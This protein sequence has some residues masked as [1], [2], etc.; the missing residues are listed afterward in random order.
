[1]CFKT[2]VTL[3]LFGRWL[4]VGD[5]RRNFLGL[6]I[7]WACLKREGVNHITRAA[8]EQRA[9]MLEFA[10]GM[11]GVPWPLPAV[12]RWEDVRDVSSAS[13]V[14]M[15]GSGGSKAVA[16]LV[17]RPMPAGPVLVPGVPTRFV[18]RTKAA[19]GWPLLPLWTA[20]VPFVGWWNGLGNDLA[21]EVPA[22]ADEDGAIIEATSS[23]LA[24]GEGS[25]PPAS[26]AERSLVSNFEGLRTIVRILLRELIG[27][28]NAQTKERDFTPVLA[29]TL[30]L[31]QD[32]VECSSGST[33]R[34]IKSL[35]SF[36][37]VV[38]A[39]KRLMRPYREFLRTRKPGFLQ[40]LGPILPPIL[41]FMRE[42]DDLHPGLVFGA[43]CIKAEFLNTTPQGVVAVLEVLRRLGAFDFRTV[44]GQP[45]ANEWTKSQIVAACL[46]GYIYAEL[47]APARSASSAEA[48]SATKATFGEAINLFISFSADALGGGDSS[49]AGL[50]ELLSHVKTIVG[51][52]QQEPHISPKSLE[53]ALGFINSAAEGARLAEGFKHGMGAALMADAKLLLVSGELDAQCEEQFLQGAQNIL[54][55]G[56]ETTDDG[57]SWIV[58][59]DLCAAQGSSNDMVCILSEGVSNMAEVMA[60]WS[61]KH[62]LDETESLCELLNHMARHISIYDAGKM[63]RCVE[64]LS[65]CRTQWAD[66]LTTADGSAWPPPQSSRRKVAA[67][68]APTTSPACTSWRPRS[69]SSAPCRCPRPSP[70]PRA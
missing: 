53:E 32:A 10:F 25:P 49:F 37:E 70:C 1:M 3:S 19:T 28:E 21:P 6:L 30:K 2:H 11:A 62:M 54:G 55:T 67:S 64:S 18:S 26:A 22:D 46:T 68:P 40:Q 66:A 5:N 47:K 56:L 36:V 29:K 69:R 42:S 43:A 9:S 63:T 16:A 4:K 7:A 59:S 15:L 45:L 12:M 31:K 34:L 65:G 8:I 17:P 33:G 14:P 61:A 39:A 51:A 13:F 57:A 35:E 38:S 52:A 23:A 44:V 60:Q 27:S 50:R 24:A 20:D 41:Q 48:W 58:P